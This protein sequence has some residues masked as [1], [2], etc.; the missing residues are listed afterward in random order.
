MRAL[1]ATGGFS[2]TLQD[3][4]DCGIV[5]RLATQ[6]LTLKVPFLRINAAK[7]AE[8][9]RL[10]DL[11][12][13]V[14]NGILAL[15]QEE[16]SDLTTAHFT[17]VEIGSAWM[18]QTIRNARARTKAKRFT[19]MLLETNNQNWTLYKVGDT[20]S[21]GFNLLRGVKKRIPLEVYGVPCQGLLDAL[22]EG[23]AKQGSLKVWRSRRGI[24]YALLSV[25]M[26]VPDIE[27]VRG[28]VGVDRGQRHLAVA[29]TTSAAPHV[30]HSE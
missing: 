13:K 9:A 17:D 15:S 19:V 25:S 22:L 16:R 5:K 7:A 21:L 29:S 24:W 11:N 30:V 20:Y 10:Q 18:N 23:R 26:E 6:T 28:W 14:A 27:P 8:F 12:T 1:P 4:H 3:Q 2:P